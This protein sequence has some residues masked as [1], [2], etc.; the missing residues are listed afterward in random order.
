MNGA[1]D[2][3]TLGEL[4]RDTRG[5]VKTGPFGTTLSA[6]EYSEQGVPVV[7]VGEVGYGVFRIHHETRRVGPDVLARLPE[8]QLRLG[9]I[10]F[11]RKG[12]VDRSATVRS[13]QVGWFLGSDGIR[14]RLGRGVD[15]L[16]V[17]YALLGASARQWLTTNSTG[18]TMATLN[19]QILDRVP[20]LLPSTSEQN[21]IVA[22][23]DDTSKLIAS[24]ERLI[25]KKRDVKQG[26][27]QELL[28]GRTR[29]PGFTS[30]WDPRQLGDLGTFLKGRGIKRDDVRPNGVPC[31]RYGELYTT[32]QNYTASTVSFVSQAVADTALPIRDGD[33]LFAGS[34]ETKDEIGMTVA[35]VG[36]PPA[37][38]GGDIIVLRGGGYDPVFIATLLNTPTVARQ[39][40]RAG[41]GDA[42]VHIHARA[43]AS[44][45]LTIPHLDEQRAIA[46]ILRDADAEIAA[47]E[48]RLESA[49]AI[50]Q[51]MM[52]ELLTGCTRLVGSEPS[53]GSGTDVPEVAA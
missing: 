12:A 29:L 5:S 1:P 14:V 8:Y 30:Q 53:T 37:V 11:G 20:L 28:T 25:A 48:R 38:A 6:S 51:G 2:A 3:I 45:A 7:S 18:T 22:T 47:L 10:V 39:K 19:Q 26:L 24:L 31:I 41:Q 4:V 43:L 23:L 33:L 36:N 9:D 21:A 27:T 15:P 44:I 34:G 46:K 17:G 50:K 13:G 49:R 32:F 35:Y 42:V 40:A 16:Y 52:Q